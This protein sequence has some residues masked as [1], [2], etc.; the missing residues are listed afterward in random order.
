[1]CSGYHCATDGCL[2][3]WCR[4][5]CVVC[6]LNRVFFCDSQS[7]F[8]RDKLGG[9]APA[10]L[11]PTFVILFLFTSMELLDI[12][13][14]GALSSAHGGDGGGV[15]VPA[16][17]C[18]SALTDSV[19]RCWS[20]SS[21]ASARCAADWM[22]FSCWWRETSLRP[23]FCAP[24]RPGSV[25]RCRTPP[26][27]WLASSCSERTVTE[28]SGGA[29]GGG[30]CNSGWCRDVAVALQ[31]FSP[32]LESLIVHCKPFYSLFGSSYTIV[33]VMFKFLNYFCL[34]V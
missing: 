21:P 1:M 25:D 23:P 5:F 31:R 24:R 4:S 2:V 26:S 19:Q 28:L 11:L 3:C 32:D 17:W 30:V 7:P 9:A 6:V 8:T 18:I 29:R 10:D 16:C 27:G 34:S 22:N 20:C 14:K 15:D 12:V 33:N 13:F